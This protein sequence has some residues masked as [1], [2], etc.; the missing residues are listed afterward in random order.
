[1]SDKLKFWEQ[2]SKY[3]EE[4]KWEMKSRN[5]VL[6]KI[7]RERRYWWNKLF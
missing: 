5:M 3:L 6:N 2:A 1:M 4:L 7:E